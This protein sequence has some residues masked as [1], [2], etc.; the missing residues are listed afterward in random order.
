M[1]LAK[2]GLEG[3]KPSYVSASSLISDDDHA[4]PFG[5]DGHSAT[6]ELRPA[7]ATD[8]LKHIENIRNLLLEHGKLEKYK[9]VYKLMFVSTTPR[10]CIGGHIHLGHELIKGDEYTTKAYR[11]KLVTALDNLVAFPLMFIENP[12]DAKYRK[13]RYG[14]FSDIRIKTYGI[15]YRTP[16]SW[17]A[18]EELAKGVITLAYAVGHEVLNNG[19]SLKNPVTRFPVFSEAFRSHSL[20]LLAP[21]LET[22]RKTI[23][24]LEL[25]PEYKKHIDYLLYHAAHK[26]VLANEEIKR[27]WK[28]PYKT[29]RKAILYSLMQL[30]QLMAENLRDNPGQG[31]T[32]HSFVLKNSSDYMIPSIERNVNRAICKSLSEYIGLIDSYETVAI[33][34]RAKEHGDSILIQYRPDKISIEKM[35][36]LARIIHDTIIG[37]GFPLDVKIEV[38]KRKEYTSG[39]DGHYDAPIRIGFGR[40][41][42]EYEKYL[43]EVITFLCVLYANNGIYKS[44]KI[45]RKTGKKVELPLLTRSIV[46]TIKTKLGEKARVE[47]TME[48]KGAI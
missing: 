13:E 40:S 10:E 29:V 23:K 34:A 16:S 22:V 36:K 39:Y 42:R 15:E 2:P 30:V 26:H 33:F 44:Y 47:T 35:H 8:P 21:H 12:T 27:G 18:R 1:Y 37:F 5:L 6:A 28:L 41:L 46:K 45:H 24:G 7:P 31:S 4:I 19:W 38:Q 20:D 9:D 43:C 48:N 14:R 3:G 25:Y 17:L 11:D 32:T